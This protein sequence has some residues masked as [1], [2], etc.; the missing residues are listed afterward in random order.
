MQLEIV[1]FSADP[2]AAVTQGAIE[3]SNVHSVMEMTRMV[4]ITR[5]YTQMAGLLSQ[6]HDMRRNTLDKLAEVPA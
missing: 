1:W 6:H 3:K 5:T 2:S 4:E